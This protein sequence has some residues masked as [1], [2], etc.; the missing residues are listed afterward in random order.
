VDGGPTAAFGDIDQES[1]SARSSLLPAHSFGSTATRRKAIE[2]SDGFRYC[3]N[4]P[5]SLLPIAAR[6]W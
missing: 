2:N 4:V 5:R 1:R 6:P 3:A